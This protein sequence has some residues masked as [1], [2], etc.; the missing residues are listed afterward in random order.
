MA[1]D[2]SCYVCLFLVEVFC[3]L[4]HQ[5]I[6]TDNYVKCEMKQLET[7]DIFTVGYALRL[8]QN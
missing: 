8:K 2:V 1:T 3:S 5:G 6:H 4:S 7:D